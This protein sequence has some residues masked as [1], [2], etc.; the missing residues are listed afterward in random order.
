MKQIIF[1]VGRIAKNMDNAEY[2]AAQRVEKEKEQNFNAW[3]KERKK[4]LQLLLQQEIPLESGY[5]CYGFSFQLK[6]ESYYTSLFISFEDTVYFQARILPGALPGT[7][8]PPTP[9]W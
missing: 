4:E 3:K 5:R 9:L 8:S 1:H 7:S 2:Q 6:K